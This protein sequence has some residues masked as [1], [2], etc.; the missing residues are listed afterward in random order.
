MPN[1]Q[2]I[3]RLAG[4]LKPVRRR[5][6]RIEGL[7]LMALCVLE[8]ALF[9]GMGQARPDMHMA[10]GLPSF[11]W[12]LGSMGLIAVAGG[13][14]AIWSLDPATSPR[15]GLRLLIIVIA[16]CFATGWLVDAARA[17]IPTLAARLAWHDG[18]Q[19]VYK[20]VSDF[21]CG[22]GRRRILAARP[23]RWASPRR[24]GVRS[25]SSLPARMTIRFTSPFGTLWDADW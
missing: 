16:L 23:W 9:L 15:R 13:V 14:T 3:D 7:L 2:L 11:W 19:C 1:N 4:D 25:C 20:M 24:P 12:K 8:L 18:L 21:L 22:G 6:P 17:G 10:M 5:S